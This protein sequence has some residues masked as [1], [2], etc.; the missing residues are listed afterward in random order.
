[1]LYRLCVCVCVCEISEDTDSCDVYWL[2]L[3]NANFSLDG[4]PSLLYLAI[5]VCHIPLLPR[6]ACERPAE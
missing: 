3:L 5:S 2:R 4:T 1:M 6:L